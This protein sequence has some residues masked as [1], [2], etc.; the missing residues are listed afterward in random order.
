MPKTDL[1][2]HQRLIAKVGGQAVALLEYT[3]CFGEAF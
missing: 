3:D 2:P 1:L